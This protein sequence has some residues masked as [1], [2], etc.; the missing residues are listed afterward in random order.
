MAF[1]LF[2]S[3]SRQQ[4]LGIAVLRVVTGIVFVMHGY[5][6]VFVYGFAGTAG[7]FTKMGIFMPSVMG[8]FIALLELFGGL[9]LIIGL[10]TRLAA[11]GL[12]FDML[13]AILMVHLAGGFYLPSGYEFALTLLAACVA[14]VLAG[15]GSPSADD[16]IASR[17]PGP[18][19]TRG[20]VAR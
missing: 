4:R 10:L 5:Q 14:L 9:A 17:R 18:L 13:G 20:T 2:A 7:A 11:L 1:D 12:A 6:K 15:P 3:G 19:G 8:P 16:A